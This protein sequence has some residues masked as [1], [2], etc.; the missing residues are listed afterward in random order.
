MTCPVCEKR[1]AQ[2]LR[3]LSD[4]EARCKEMSTKNQRLTLALTV[5]ATLAGKESIDLALGLSSSLGEL[6]A[7]VP[8][9]EAEGQDLAFVSPGSRSRRPWNSQG[10]TVLTVPL[11]PELPALT[12]GLRMA[13]EFEGLEASTWQLEGEQLFVPE[14]SGLAL[15]FFAGW[16]PRKRS[17]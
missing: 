12:P 2:E 4:C 11:F 1:K 6:T 5:L 3:Q 13:N 17:T 10:D 15:V 16:K 9:P 14:T 8:Q 7:S